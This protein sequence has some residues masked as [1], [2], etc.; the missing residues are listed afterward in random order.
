MK[1]EPPIVINHSGAAN[2]ERAIVVPSE[3]YARGHA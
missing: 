2:R 3:V 1:N